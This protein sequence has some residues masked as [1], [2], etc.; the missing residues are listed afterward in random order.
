MTEGRTSGR[1]SND[2][3]GRNAGI[4][5]VLSRR[6]SNGWF[7][8]VVYAYND[9][10]IDAN[11]GLGEYD[12][13]FNRPHFF[14][15]GGSWEINERWKVG[16]RWK[17]ASG[18]PTDD[19]VINEDVLG[20]GEPLRYSKELTRSNALRLEN[21]HSLNIRVDYRRPL[22]WV[23]LIAFI[24]VINVYGGP[25]A[26]SLEFDPRNGVNIVEDNEAFPIFG[27]IFERAW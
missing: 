24:D 21:Y 5:V 1:V 27:L 8:N 20:P 10:R 6:F 16:A 12:A 3:D 11:D 26:N 23:D 4:D 7:A 25:G 18:R 19:F 2:G 17:W 14:S 9:S 15:A 22:G 13:D